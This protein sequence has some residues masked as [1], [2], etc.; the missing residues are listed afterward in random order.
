MSIN[1]IISEFHTDKA[2]EATEIMKT[3]KKTS[4]K[5]KVVSNSNEK[6]E[7]ADKKIKKKDRFYKV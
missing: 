6:V 1:A 2:T 4:I 3:S 7:K 5:K